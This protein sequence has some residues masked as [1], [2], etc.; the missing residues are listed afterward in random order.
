MSSPR[1]SSTSTSLGTPG[2]LPARGRKR[3]RAAGRSLPRVLTTSKLEEA[4]ATYRRF[5]LRKEEEGD[6]VA[7]AACYL[8]IGD[9]Y[10]A[11]GESD[12]AGEMYRRSLEIS[13]DIGGYRL[14]W[15]L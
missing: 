12:R 10:L 3:R 4:V 1:S 15:P 6:R 8:E 7:M 14:A 13:R 11:R 9:L 5:L 2:A